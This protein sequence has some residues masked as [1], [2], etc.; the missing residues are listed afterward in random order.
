MRACHWAKERC[1]TALAVSRSN[2][3]TRLTARLYVGRKAERRSG[4]GADATRA[5]S[6]KVIS[7]DQATTA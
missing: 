4:G 7:L 3:E 2:R 5:A 6:A 1:S